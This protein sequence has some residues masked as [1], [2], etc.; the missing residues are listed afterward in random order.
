MAEEEKDPFAGKATSCEIE[1]FLQSVAYK[2]FCNV[3][4]RRIE[5]ITAEVLVAESMEKIKYLQGEAAGV[6]FWLDFGP[7]MKEYLAVVEEQEA[8]GVMK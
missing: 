2:D 5:R 7:R 4:Q 3:A 8:K 1:Q 6:R